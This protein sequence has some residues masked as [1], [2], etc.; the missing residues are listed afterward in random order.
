MP[1]YKANITD[2]LQ[3]KVEEAAYEGGI[4]VKENGDRVIARASD[5]S[6]YKNVA[7]VV[8]R[9]DDSIVKFERDD[10]GKP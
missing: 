7:G 5:G 2:V 8:I 4:P 1:T 10:V 6:P 3:T 9:T